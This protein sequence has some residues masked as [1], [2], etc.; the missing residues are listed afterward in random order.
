MSKKRLRNLT[1]DQRYALEDEGHQ[2]LRAFAELMNEP[3]SDETHIPV[4]QK[5]YEWAKQFVCINKT[6]YLRYMNTYMFDVNTRKSINS[7]KK[8]LAPYIHRLVTKNLNK[9]TP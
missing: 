5:H 2:L 1:D 7:V 9:I 8:D 4:V 3:Y 6:G